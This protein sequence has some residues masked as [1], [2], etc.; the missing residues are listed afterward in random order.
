MGG[1]K[2]KQKILLVED[3]DGI[4]E[5]YRMKLELEKYDV[6]TAGD[7]KEALRLIK[8]RKPGLVLL[9]ILLPQKDGFEV[10]SEVRQS[11]DKKVKNIPVVI[12]SNLS[13]IDDR[14]EAEKLGASGYLVKAEVTPQEVADKASELLNPVKN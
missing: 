7:G 2:Q 4:R 14:E 9:D 12:L 3:D 8:K 13:H 10:L 11:E 5:M 6:M 1:L